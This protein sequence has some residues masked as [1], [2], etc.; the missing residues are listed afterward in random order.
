MCAIGATSMFKLKLGAGLLALTCVIHKETDCE[1]GPCYLTAQCHKCKHSHSSCLRIRLPLHCLLRHRLLPLRCILPCPPSSSSSSAEVSGLRSRGA[2]WAEA[3]KSS[4]VGPAAPAGLPEASEAW[5][6]EVMGE[7]CGSMGRNVM[8]LTCWSSPS[9]LRT[10]S[11]CQSVMLSMVPRW[12]EFSP[13]METFS[14]KR[15]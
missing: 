2:I 10:T 7:I 1:V 4:C 15:S 12:P 9:P 11:V 5:L 14:S 8:Q 3:D 6:S 13:S